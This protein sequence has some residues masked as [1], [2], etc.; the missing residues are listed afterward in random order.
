MSSFVHGAA[1][2]VRGVY[3]EIDAATEAFRRGSGLACVEGCGACCRKPGIEARVV[4]MLPAALALTAAGTAAEWHERATA[5]ADGACVFYQPDPEDPRRGRCGN[6]EHRPSVCRLFG[7]AAV[8]RRDGRPELASCRPMKDAFAATLAALDPAAAPA[9]AD[10]GL[11]VGL[12]TAH[13]GL[14]ELLPINTALARAL[15]KAST[16]GVD[17]ERSHR[18]G[19]DRTQT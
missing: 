2:S 17:R 15:E 14:S 19:A 3:T 1:A 16:V 10:Y 6:Y 4:E 9:F 18:P 7:F 13:S 12:A 11:K 5:V 8:K